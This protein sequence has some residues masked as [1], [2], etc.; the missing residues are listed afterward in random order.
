MY[1]LILTTACISLMYYNTETQ[2]T[3]IAKVLLAKRLGGRFADVFHR[4]QMQYPRL[5][6]RLS[7]LGRLC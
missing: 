1:S 4:S 2:L 5:S 3:G 7:A 6:P